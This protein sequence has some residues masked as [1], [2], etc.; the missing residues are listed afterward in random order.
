MN[1]TAKWIVGLAG[2]VIAS[3]AASFLL[4][5]GFGLFDIRVP[6]MG[7]S[8]VALGIGAVGIMKIN[9]WTDKG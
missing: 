7:L 3:G 8:A 4:V 6:S 5:F 9:E 1:T 2:V